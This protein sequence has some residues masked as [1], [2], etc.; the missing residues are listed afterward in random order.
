[1]LSM[2]SKGDI[3]VHIVDVLSLLLLVAAFRLL[4]AMS[5]L[6]LTLNYAE[7]F[8]LDDVAACM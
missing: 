8:L 1:M 4:F 2:I 7:S 3:T 6:H 5:A